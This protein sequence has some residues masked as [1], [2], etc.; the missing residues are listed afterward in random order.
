M[1]NFIVAESTLIRDKRRNEIESSSDVNN[2]KSRLPIFR[3]SNFDKL[4]LQ[5]EEQVN[6]VIRMERKAHNAIKLKEQNTLF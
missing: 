4:A 6:K 5:N 2:I 3:N 1:C